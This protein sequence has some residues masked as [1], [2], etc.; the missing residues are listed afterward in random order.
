MNLRF[1]KGELTPEQETLI[2]Q[3]GQAYGIAVEKRD[4]GELVVCDLTTREFARLAL[5]AAEHWGIPFNSVKVLPVTE[6]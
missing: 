3:A 1:L 4:S 6:L 5:G 2:Q